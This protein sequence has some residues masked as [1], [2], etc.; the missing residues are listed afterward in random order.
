MPA[1]PIWDG[2]GN[3]YGT[4]VYGG[5]APSY[6]FSGGNG[7]GVIYEMTPNPDGS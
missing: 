7:C 4:T 3:L 6:C 1:P 5:N 2:K